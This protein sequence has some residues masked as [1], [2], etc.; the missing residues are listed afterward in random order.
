[1]SKWRLSRHKKRGKNGGTSKRLFNLNEM[2]IS[3]L[4]LSGTRNIPS[5]C[6]N[7]G[8]AWK[9]E[10]SRHAQVDFSRNEPNVI[11][12]ATIEPIAVS[13]RVYILSLFL[14]LTHGVLGI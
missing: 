13:V 6:S 12:A 11:H 4:G 2:G 14:S 8:R 9:I 3:T 1:V 10:G 5:P 7:D